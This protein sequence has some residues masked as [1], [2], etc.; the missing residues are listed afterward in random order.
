MFSEAKLATFDSSSN[1]S[2]DSLSAHHFD[3]LSN[4]ELPYPRIICHYR[5]RRIQIPPSDFNILKTFHCFHV[6]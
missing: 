5:N 2:G 1:V 3:P 6:A 4:Y